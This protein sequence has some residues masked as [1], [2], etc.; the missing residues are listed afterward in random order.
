MQTVS[1][2]IEALGGNA[3]FGRIIGKRPS[4]ASEMKRRGSIPVEYWPVVTAAA[5]EAGLKIQY[6]DLV[7]MHVA[8]PQ[9][10]HQGSAA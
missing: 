7:A 10:E 4:T 6:A 8:Q 9:P 1:N 5:G 3:A 2:L